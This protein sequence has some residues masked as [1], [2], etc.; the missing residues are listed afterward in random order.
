MKNLA[1]KIDNL[2]LKYENSK[3]SVE[4]LKGINL[5]IDKGEAVI[6][7]GISGS[8][9]SSLLGVIAGLRKPYSGEVLINSKP[10]AK[11]SDEVLSLFRGKYIG[12]VFQNY[13]LV[14]HLSVEHNVSLPLLPMKLGFKER[15]KLVSIAMKKAHIEHKSKQI[16]T[17]LSG[18]EKQRVS[19][20]RALAPNPDI[21]ICDEPTASLDKV[22]KEIFIDIIRTLHKKGNTILIATHDPIFATLDFIT[23]IYKIDNGQIL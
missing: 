18:G 21:L 2:V 23:N 11:L 19:I 10:I 17:T 7:Q 20:A 14:E 1:I 6:L 16:A 15:N 9:K 8:G 5:Q 22:N 13:R 4:I 3:E 12:M